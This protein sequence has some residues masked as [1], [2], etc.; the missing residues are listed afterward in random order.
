MGLAQKMVVAD[1]TMAVSRYPRAA[2][3]YSCGQAVPAGD[4][5]LGKRAELAPLNCS[6][7]AG[8]CTEAL[9]AHPP[10]LLPSASTAP[11]KKS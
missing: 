11:P 10:L 1:Y 4:A 3:L 9:S 2:P 8:L 5:L 6:K 7:Y